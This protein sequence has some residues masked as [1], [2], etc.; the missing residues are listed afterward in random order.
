MTHQR[1]VRLAEKKERSVAFIVD[2]ALR[3]LLARHESG[4]L[5]LDLG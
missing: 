2:R 5:D 4:Q 1:L 3:D